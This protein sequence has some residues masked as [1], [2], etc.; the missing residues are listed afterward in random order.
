MLDFLAWFGIPFILLFVG[1]FAKK[2]ARG[3][4]W[5]RKDWF[6]GPE[7]AL[8]AFVSALTLALDTLRKMPMD[9]KTAVPSEV[10]RTLLLSLISC[11]F[12]FA[13]IFVVLSFHRD[14]EPRDVGPRQQRIYLLGV[15]NLAGVVAM[16]SFLLFVKP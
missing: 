2:L 13:A 15:C 5:S 14:Y 9:G 7:L 1:G 16:A 4:G 12:Y 3:R 6:M 8:T 10:T 11:G